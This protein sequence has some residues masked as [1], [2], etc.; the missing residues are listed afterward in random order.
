MNERERFIETLLFGKPDKIPL[1]LGF[2]REL[3]LERWR[4]EGLLPGDNGYGFLL[5]EI[6]VTG[7]PDSPP[8]LP[9]C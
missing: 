4:K 9:G 2:P 7:G 5:K 8:P 1:M 6:G 3:T